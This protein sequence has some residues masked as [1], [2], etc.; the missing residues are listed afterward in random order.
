MSRAS[1]K[2][3]WSQ[4]PAW[5]ALVLG[6]AALIGG[7]ARADRSQLQPLDATPE[8][9]G[10]SASRSDEVAVRIDGENIYISQGGGAFEELHLGDTPE[11]AHFRKL[12]RDAGA[13]GQSVSV[14][15]GSTIVASGGGGHSGQKPKQKIA[16]QIQE[17]QNDPVAKATQSCPQNIALIRAASEYRQL[18][19]RARWSGS[20][21][22]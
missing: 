13:A 10:P 18:G 6:F 15:V 16:G 2:N 5:G 14:P 22:V 12:L 19:R 17:R 7:E 4:L 9:S 21:V 20:E 8:P 11:A 1:L 3:I